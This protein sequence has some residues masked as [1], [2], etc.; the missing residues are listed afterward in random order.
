M[1]S[2]MIQPRVGCLLKKEG[3]YWRIIQYIVLNFIFSDPDQKKSMA[4]NSMVQGADAPELALQCLL[5]HVACLLVQS[6]NG[7]LPICRNLETSH[8]FHSNSQE[9]TLNL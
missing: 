7:G 6:W 8:E 2:N 4:E 1:W 9:E 5:C 3:S